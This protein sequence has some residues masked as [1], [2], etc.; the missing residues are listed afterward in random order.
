MFV[1]DE[2]LRTFIAH[3]PLPFIG[4]VD[5]RTNT[6]ES[7]VIDQG[8]RQQLANCQCLNRNVLFRLSNRYTTQQ[9]RQQNGSHCHLKQSFLIKL[10]F[11]RPAKPKP[12]LLEPASVRSA[13]PY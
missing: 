9:Y 12:H 10:V 7:T 2:Y 3:Q 4:T 11:V 6:D 1:S 5:S 13:T 8:M